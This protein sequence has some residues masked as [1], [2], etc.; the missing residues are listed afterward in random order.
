MYDPE[1]ARTMM[2]YFAADPSVAQGAVAFGARTGHVGE[3]GKFGSHDTQAA[4]GGQSASQVQFP[5]MPSMPFSQMYMP[6]YSYGAQSA[7]ARSPAFSFIPTPTDT[8]THTHTHK[9]IPYSEQAYAPYG[10]YMYKPPGMFQGSGS[11]P[12]ASSTGSFSDETS[13]FASKG[14]AAATFPQVP[15][16]E[17]QVRVFSTSSYLSGVICPST[18]LLSNPQ[19]PAAPKSAAPGSKV[20]APGESA[21][22]KQASGFSSGRSDAAPF[23]PYFGVNSPF[24]ATHM[25]GQQPTYSPPGRGSAQQ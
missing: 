2:Q 14:P 7:Q 1:N 22:P 3:P 19:L 11:A 15:Y 25:M 23:S 8:Q 5:G 6:Y 18:Y 20:H 16:Y 12:G 4:A 24:A 17:S 10:R 13:D 21:F 9:A